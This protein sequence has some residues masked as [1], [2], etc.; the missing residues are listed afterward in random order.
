MKVAVEARL[1]NGILYEAAKKLGSISA[2][3]RY[4]G[5]RPVEVGQ[6]I[7]FKRSAITLTELGSHRGNRPKERT[8]EFWQ[9]IENKLFDLTGHTL[10]EIFPPEIR[11]KA[12]LEREKRMATVVDMSIEQLI[13]AGA[14]PQLPPAPDELLFAKESQETIKFVLASLTPNQEKV[15][16]M[17]F[18]LDG[19]S[20]HTLAEVAKAIGVTVERVRQ[21]EKQA[22]F[23]MRKRP[24]RRQLK[25][26]SSGL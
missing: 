16:R 5:L 13:A 10:E 7:N 6:W 12:F 9:E 8:S 1:K 4:L 18:G 3:A 23:K 19:G 26:F 15:I 21:I 2:L 22:L 14:V 20:E 17:R 24:L 11:S 25:R